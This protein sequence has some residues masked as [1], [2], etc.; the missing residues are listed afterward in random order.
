MGATATTAASGGNRESL[1]GP[2]PAG[3]EQQRGRRWEPQPGLGA[4]A[5]EKG[6]PEPIAFLDGDIGDDD[7]HDD[8]KTRDEE[9]KVHMDEAEI[10][11]VQEL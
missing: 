2:R 11:G 1:L 9:G 6:L 3:C 10:L 4:S 8:H 5:P 7:A